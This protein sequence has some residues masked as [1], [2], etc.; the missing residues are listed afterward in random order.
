MNSQTDAR[1]ASMAGNPERLLLGL[2]AIWIG[3]A[4]NPWL[5]GRLLFE[6]G[7]APAPIDLSVLLMDFVV[8][9][10]GVQLFRCKINLRA[11]IAKVFLFSF[12]S[13]GFLCVLVYADRLLGKTVLRSHGV[14]F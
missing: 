12:T 6:S 3:L 8:I 1:Q 11:W 5:L 4:V 9:V 13:L 10:L 14:I 7:S 2:L